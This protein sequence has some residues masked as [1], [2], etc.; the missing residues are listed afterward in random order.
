MAWRLAKSLVT[1]RGEVN[2]WAPNRSKASD[3]TIGDPAHASR[4]SRHNPNRYGV[5]TALDI[6]HDPAGGCDVHALA[7]RLVRAP[8]PELAYVISNRQISARSGGWAW[9]AYTGTNP[10]TVH[11]HFAVG[12]GPDSDPAPPYDSTAPWGVV[13]SPTSPT[14]KEDA[15]MDVIIWFAPGPHAYKVNGVHATHIKTQAD[16]DVLKNFWKI[17]EFNTGATASPATDA[18]RFLD[19]PLKNTA[20][21]G[22]L[23]W[24]AN[25][26]KATVAAQGGS[27]AGVAA[28]FAKRLAA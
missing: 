20:S 24:L 27:A 22:D 26:V 25:D 18:T 13:P 8:H 17:P 23:R 14:P 9:R 7:R 16:L 5:V 19:G 4:P 1:L 3:G 12:V 15:D 11:A 21:L 10:H 2:A 28:E 6:T